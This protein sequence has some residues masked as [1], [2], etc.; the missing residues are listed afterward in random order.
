MIKL[1]VSKRE[2]SKYQLLGHKPGGG[3]LLACRACDEVLL[4]SPTGK[5]HPLFDYAYDAYPEYVVPVLSTNH[6]LVLTYFED[7]GGNLELNAYD[8]TGNL[9][10][11]L[12]SVFLQ[13][14]RL[15]A[16][17][18]YTVYISIPGSTGPDVNL[19]QWDVRTDPVDTGLRNVVAIDPAHDQMLRKL[20][21]SWTPTLALSSISDPSSIRW[22]FGPHSRYSTKEYWP[23]SFSPD[24]SKL[25]GLDS[26][27]QRLVV[28]S[29][30]TGHV[31][32]ALHFGNAPLETA[33][34]NNTHLLIEVTQPQHPKEHA[35]LRCGMADH[36]TR[37]TLWQRRSLLDASEAL[38]LN[39]L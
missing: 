23:V 2:Q 14:A 27:G 22:S 16:F 5:V 28:R 37:T 38:D 9:L 19:Y 1:A 32:T 35:L 3:W 33:W 7:P 39:A 6:R 20:A 21:A 29:T 11:A 12:G 31:I 18:D 13:D 15:V 24:G 25:V 26:S 4:A 36:C 30:S 8:L 17:R 34:E 10:G